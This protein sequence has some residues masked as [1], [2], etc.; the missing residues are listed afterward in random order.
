MFIFPLESFRKA[1]PAMGASNS[2][3]IR[4]GG[5]NI[6]IK[7][8]AASMQGFGPKMEDAYT[9]APDLDHTTSFFGVYDGHRG[10]EVA[11]LCARLFH[12]ELRVHPDYQRNLNN[13]I[14]SVF[15]RMDQVLRQSNEWRQLLNP[16]GSRNWIE[17]VLCPIANPW[18]CIEETPYRPPQST[19][20]TVCVAVTRG[21]QVIVGNVGDSHCVASRNGQA[22]L[23][24]TGHKPY[25]QNERQ[26]IE[27]AGGMLDIDNNVVI[28]GGQVGGF[29][30]IEGKLSTSRAIGDFVF[31]KNKHLPPEEQM[32]ICNPDI[33]DMEITNDIEFLVMGSRGLWLSM[34]YQEAVDY[35]HAM[36][37]SGETDLHVICERLMQRARPTI[38]DTTVILIQLNHGDPAD[39]GEI[40]EAE[41]DSKSDTSD[42]NEI[43]PAAS[44]EEQPFA[45][46][47]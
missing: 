46:N 31:K 11:L 1:N 5:E 23:L 29:S 37:E 40:E 25:H 36:L 21:N 19:G 43:K 14:R 28:E 10:A 4:T 41:E 34:T 16:T 47:G 38:N 18:Y 7:Y 17:R 42:D 3:D 12:I 32:V 24:S 44:E 26:R 9:V 6:R 20:S 35:V 39:A 13:A 27:R 45:P 33:H 8:A 30:F 15:S 2:R 22:I